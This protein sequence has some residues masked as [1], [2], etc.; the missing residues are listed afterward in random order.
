MTGHPDNDT[1]SSIMRS[2]PSR[3]VRLLEMNPEHQWRPE[4]FAAVLEHQLSAPMNVEWDSLD[5]ELAQ[6]LRMLSEADGL[7]LRSFA[8][9]LY[10]PHPP[11]ELLRLTKDFAKANRHLRGSY[12][13]TE[14]ATV[15]Y[16]A[17]IVSALVRCRERI[18][19]LSDSALL[20]G[21]DWVLAQPW[22]SERLK[23]LFRE[24]KAGL[25]PTRGKAPDPAKI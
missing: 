14:V 24:G 13:P 23:D 22:V 16:Y 5:P 9:L 1:T 4:E 20:E 21:I 6:K 10:H 11:V 25:K 8:D 7:L 18:T 3:L 19:Q 17:S 2:D 12:L 15:L